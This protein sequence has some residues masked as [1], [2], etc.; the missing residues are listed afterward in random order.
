MVPRRTFK[1]VLATLL[2][3]LAAGGHAADLIKDSD[4][5]DCHSDD[6][7]T[8]TNEAGRAVSLYVNESVLRASVHGTNTC[9]ACHED[10]TSKHP[11]DEVPAKPV[12]CASCHERQSE[13]YGASVH[14][15]A[16]KAGDASAPTCTD[17]HDSHGLKPISDPSSPLHFSNLTKTCG[18]CH[19]QAA[20]DVGASIH[21][22]AA[23]NGKRE[24]ATCIDCH[25]E[26][27]IEQLKTAGTLKIS[28]DVC[29]KCHASERINTKFNLPKDRVETFFASYHGL[30]S[31]Y[32]S[33]LAANCASCHGYHLVLPSADPRSTIS[34]NNLVATCGKCHPGATEKFA[35]GKIHVADVT[36]AQAGD[37]GGKTNAWVRRIYI[38]L[39]L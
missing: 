17:C 37:F 30:A 6:T 21:G 7:L 15:L 33:A 23:A 32:G 9:Q 10:L 1:A 5:L 28:A 4:C 3:V 34:T 29:S 20:A 16:A 39:S 19:E 11:D 25:A 13:S 14:G 31:Q 18:E 38:I 8:K 27:Q 24:A 35:S 26:H 22:W 12:A 2:V 36:P